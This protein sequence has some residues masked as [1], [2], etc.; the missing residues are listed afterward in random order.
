[1]LL[2]VKQQC[3]IIADKMR[4]KILHCSHIDGYTKELTAENEVK[5]TSVHL[6]TTVINFQQ[7]ML[8]A[9]A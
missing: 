7:N 1:M 4:L 5:I 2:T 3:L 6:N 9:P 8:G